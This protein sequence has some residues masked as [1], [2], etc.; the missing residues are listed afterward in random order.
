MAKKVKDK[1]NHPSHYCYHPSGIEC[2]EITEHMNFNLGNAIKYVWR[3]GSKGNMVEDLSKAIWYLNREIKRLTKLSNEKET[4]KRRASTA[5]NENSQTIDDT[6][7]VSLPIRGS[8]E[9]N[10]S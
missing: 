1:V 8:M 2:I 3:A 10:K 7:Q 5:R 6:V 4:H 9:T